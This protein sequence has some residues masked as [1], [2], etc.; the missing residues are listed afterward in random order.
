M[1]IKEQAQQ[2]MADA[3]AAAGM[4]WASDARE[5]LTRAWTTYAD[6][7]RPTPY[8]DEGRMTKGEINAIQSQYNVNDNAKENLEQAV[9]DVLGVARPHRDNGRWCYPNAPMGNM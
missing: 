6:E 5:R 8:M 1:S 9:C 4:E 7:Y 2:L 3:K